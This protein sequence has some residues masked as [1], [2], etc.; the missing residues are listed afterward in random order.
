MSWTTVDDVT[1]MTGVV[2]SAEVLA[3]ADSIVT[4]YC[5]RTADLKDQLRKRDQYWLAQATAW[6]AA[7]LAGQAGVTARNLG[8]RIDTEGLSVDHAAEYEVVL[9]PLAARALRNLSWKSSRTVRVAVPDYAGIGAR[10]FT[11][12]ASDPYQDWTPLW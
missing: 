8:T 1:E 10:N 7:W 12:E 6:Q 11:L 4:I 9:A 3:Q 2:V 5:G